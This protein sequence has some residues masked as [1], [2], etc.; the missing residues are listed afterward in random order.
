MAGSG[1]KDFTIDMRM[2]ADFSAARKAVR[3]TKKDLQDLADTAADVSTPDAGGGPSTQAQQAYVQ[4][5][6]LTQENIAAEIALIGKLQARLDRGASS[7]EDLADTETMLDKAMSKGLITAEEYDAA[8]AS[9]D[10]SQASLERSTAKQQKTLDATVSRYDKAGSQLRQLARDEVALKKARDSGRLSLEQYNRALAGLNDKRTGV[11]YDANQAKK[12]AL[13][14]LSPAVA[15]RQVAVMKRLSFQTAAT[16]RDLTQLAIYT[17]RGDWHLASNQV[18]Q[19]GSRAGAASLLMSGFGLAVGAAGGAVAA[20]AV[21]AVKGYFELRALDTALIAT[22]GS[23][24]VTASA[25]AQMSREVGDSTGEYGKANEAAL[26]FAK[27]GKASADT[28]EAMIEAA[29]GLSEMTGDSIEKTTG[30]ILKLAD[31]PVPALI[32]LNR[33]YHFLS[34]AT[35]EQVQAL[36]DQGREQDAVKLGMEEL[37]RVTKTRT[38]QIR[39]NAGTLERAWEAVRKKLAEVWQAMKDIGRTDIDYQIQQL[40]KRIAAAAKIAPTSRAATEYGMEN[41]ASVAGLKAELAALQEKRKALDQTAKSD[42]AA[43]RVQDEGIEAQQRIN[44]GLKEGRSN[45]EK[46]AEATKKLTE[47]FRKLREANPDSPLLAG[48]SFGAD[49]SVSGGAFAQRLKQLQDQFKDRSSG[50]GGRKTKS[51]AQQAE[52]AA[53]REIEN[54]QRQIGLMG[55]L[56]DGET[57]LTNAARLRYEVEEGAY[58]SA[59]QATKN[60]LYDYAQMLDYEEM[61]KDAVKGLVDAQIELA[62]LQGRGASVEIARQR[63][64]LEKLAKQLE[65]IGKL[66]GA[67][68]VRK[69]IKAKEAAAELQDLQQTYDR[70]MGEIQIAQQRI[71]LGV[72]SGLVTEAQAQQQIVDLYQEK[73]ATLDKLVPQMEALA[74]A[75]GNPE[76]L[77]NVQRIKLELEGM[78][79]TT[80]QLAQSITGTFEGAFTN[81]LTTL[82]MQTASLG[83]AVRGFFLDMAQGLAQYAAQQLAAAAASKL[84]AALTQTD[85]AGVAGGADKL[86]Q[87]AGAT[88]VAG[89]AVGIGANTLS[90]AAKELAAAA[91]TLLIA[92][93]MSSA[94][95]FADGGYTGAGGKY[96]RA[97][98]V[99]RGEYVMPQHTVGYY[100]LDAMRAIHAGKARFATVGAPA[101]TRGAPALS[102]ASGGL[103]RGAEGRNS[104][105]VYLMQ[106]LDRLRAAILD[107]PSTE[108]YVVATVGQNGNAVK[109]EW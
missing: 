71:Q 91:T 84:L 107:H 21:A 56:E 55:E 35:L 45:A 65:F 52:E 92:N 70:V 3:E 25:L 77:A 37:A 6:R 24:G 28:L 32:E 2:R 103:V 17:A 54:M 68:D 74:R 64:E 94:S 61:R 13:A 66:E 42:A 51:D 100:G 97:G 105:S 43:Q 99:H 5:S 62:R 69:L 76:A 93:S 80:N 82:T 96:T 50:G 47:D 108:K 46:L 78:R 41:Q 29:V 90:N 23:A 7:W 109:A 10:K 85:S 40:E 106:D 79:N 72:Q 26:L 53:R 4:A 44:D 98:I 58:Q 30:E 22:G 75:T 36:A 34:V 33:R 87:A 86:T 1:G 27:S 8:L 38:E 48:V 83:D 73:L 88:A 89:A 19:L 15:N 49:G 14:P 102:Y 31:A 18:L 63:E 12:S 57:K 39:Q 81:L 60:A 20:F 59:S 9:L 95:G 104:M 101:V 67:A 16:Q 11:W